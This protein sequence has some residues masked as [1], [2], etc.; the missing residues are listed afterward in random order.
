MHRAGTAIYFGAYPFLFGF[1]VSLPPGLC[2]GVV[3]L[4]FSLD[5]SQV[6]GDNLPDDS[7][8]AEADCMVRR[9]L[10]RGSWQRDRH[11]LRL[12]RHFPVASAVAGLVRCAPCE[13]GRMSP[14]VTVHLLW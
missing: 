12:A 6:R 5:A 9:C 1:D 13:I 8:R 4:L 2:L 10:V 14:F 3:L 7:H 11:G